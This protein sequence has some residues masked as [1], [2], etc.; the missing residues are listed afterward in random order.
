MNSLSELQLECVC[1]CVCSKV[2]VCLLCALT[3]FTFMHALLNCSLTLEK[4]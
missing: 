2:V 4:S 3:D 1:V